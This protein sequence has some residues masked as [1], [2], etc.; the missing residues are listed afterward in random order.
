MTDANGSTAGD[1][2]LVAEEFGQLVA[3]RFSEFE[4]G[5]VESVH[6]DFE[7]GCLRVDVVGGND[8][9]KWEIGPQRDATPGDAP[10]SLRELLW[11]EVRWIWLMT[12]H[13]SFT[14]GFQI[15]F[16]DDQNTNVQLMAEAS[17]LWIY[18][19]TALDS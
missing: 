12:N 14:D 5:W 13:R 15:E 11:H 8:T 1:L 3:I 17:R 18:K 10:D 16:R 2:H 7:A 4:P 9:V 19:L 6:F